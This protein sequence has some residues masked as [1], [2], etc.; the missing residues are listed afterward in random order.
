MTDRL[1]KNPR[2]L[3][4]IGFGTLVAMTLFVAGCG[5]LRDDKGRPLTTL[6]PKGI[7]S[8]RIDDLVTPVFIVAAIVFV[9]VEGGV[10]FMSFRFR[11]RKNDVDGVDE[12]VQVHGIPRLEWTWT[13]APAILLGV[14]AIFNVRT[15]WQL[16]ERDSNAI[17]V[18]VYGQQWC[19]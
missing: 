14:L 16:E 8:N 7:Q 2:L 5:A 9:L 3:R 15:L 1:A 19:W 13:I 18:E 12:P 6:N 4:W 17:T 11:R 10:L